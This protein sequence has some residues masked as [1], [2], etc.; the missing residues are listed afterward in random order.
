ML[1]KL[2]KCETS[3]CER[4][5][6]SRHLYGRHLSWKKYSSRPVFIRHWKT[7][8]SKG[9]MVIAGYCYQG[10]FRK[11][12]KSTRPSFSILPRLYRNAISQVYVHR[13]KV[14]SHTSHSTRNFRQQMA[15]GTG[16]Q[17]TPF[18]D[19]RWSHQMPV[20]WIYAYLAYWKWPFIS[21]CHHIPKPVENL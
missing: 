6:N 2:I 17:A 20:L 18:H 19:I 9:F 8:F 5:T 14:S 12:V 13:D 3:V 11:T 1:W 4:E 21:S 15:Q 7:T 16:I 10:K